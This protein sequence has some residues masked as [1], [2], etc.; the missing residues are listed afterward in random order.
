MTEQQLYDLRDT[1][2]DIG[3]RGE[4]FVLNYERQ[5]LMHHP[6]LDKIAIAGRTDIGLGYDIISFEGLT[7]AIPDR[8]IEVKTY[9]GKP[10]FFLSQGEWAAAVK[11]ADH[12]YIYLVDISKI[13][14][15]GYEPTIIKNPAASLSTNDNWSENIQQREYTLSTPQQDPL[16]ADF[17]DSTILIGCFKDNPHKNWILH[18][19]CY[20]VRKDVVP[21]HR[22]APSQHLDD[23][24]MISRIPGA[25]TLDEI[26]TSVKYLLLYN[27]CEPRSY[28]MYQ[29]KTSHLV[30]NAGMRR[31]QYPNPRCP[32]YVLY[33]LSGV[34]DVPGIDIMSILRTN[35]DKVTRTSGTPVFM[36][37]KTFRRY[38]IDPTL[39]RM[40]GTEPPK[41]VFT[42]EGKPWSQNQS[43]RLEVLHSMH[44]DIAVIA[45]ELKRT[46]AEI[47]A[48]LKVLGLE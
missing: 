6:C 28:R 3:N 44:K 15:P 22:N 23:K 32:E 34:I 39:S 13:T 31:L 16:P 5:R 41:R 36:Q 37:G 24:K 20:N 42:N 12:Y 33:R 43:M 26:G 38:F 11:H 19:H 40:Q 4:D 30:T 18:N 8:Y 14:T 46:P 7:S 45:H 47:H 9:E 35:N 17:D 29:V 27:I 25:I 2:K 48:Q 1:K 21:Q 10:H